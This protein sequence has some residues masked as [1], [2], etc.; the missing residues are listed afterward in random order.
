MTMKEN[1]DGAMKKSQSA[2]ILRERRAVRTPN[3]PN[4][5]T[6]KGAVKLPNK[7][8]AS[9]NV[10]PKSN[11]VTPKNKDGVHLNKNLLTSSH[12]HFNPN[13]LSSRNQNLAQANARNMRSLPNLPEKTTQE[14]R[15]SM[16]RT[17]DSAR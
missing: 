1:Y 14:R 7:L 15:G 3:L 2:Q 6:I 10:I 8:G 13:A 16:F 5:P 17:S 4:L 12:S 9:R 11:S